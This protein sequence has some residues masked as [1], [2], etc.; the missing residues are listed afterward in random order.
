MATM[1]RLLAIGLLAAAT[2]VLPRAVQD[3]KALTSADPPPGAVWLD[4]LDLKKMVQRR[5][6]PRAGKSGAGRGNNPPPLS[7]GGVAYPHGI[8]TLSINELIV[9]LKGQATRFESMIGID[10]AARTGQG[11][12]TYEIWLDNKRAFA[13]KVIKAGD[14][15]QL[16]S[17]DLSGARFME[18][19]ID[20]GGD[21]STGDYADWA[22][23]L[24]R[25]KEGATEKP[26]SWTFPSEPAP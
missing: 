3:Q 11:S 4:S 19:F 16:V 21:V 26:E 7:L 12:V 6:T 2:G 18:L 10:D 25:L 9:D 22:G 24:I 8:G 15:P 13:S 17:V 14:P 23:A 5:G 1:I 20:D